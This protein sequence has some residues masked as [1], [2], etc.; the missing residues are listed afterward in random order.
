MEAVR[1]RRHAV[2]CAYLKMTM[3][4]RPGAGLVN[5]CLHIVREG[6]ECVGPFLDETPTSCGLWEEKAGA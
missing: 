4:E 5:I 1:P 3:G 6:R 2:S